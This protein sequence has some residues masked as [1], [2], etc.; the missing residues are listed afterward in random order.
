[1]QHGTPL[2]PSRNKHKM[3]DQELAASGRPFLLP[4]GGRASAWPHRD[5]KHVR[6]LGI[7]VDDAFQ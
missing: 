1:M 7:E 3:E 6:Y 2:T 4:L 5:R